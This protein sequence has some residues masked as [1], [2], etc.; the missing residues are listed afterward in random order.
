M[1]PSNPLTGPRP[2][3]G[4]R[5][6]VRSAIVGA[7]AL[8]A[9][10]ACSKS[11]EI[12]GAKSPD[13]SGV[14]TAME[15]EKCD[16]SSGQALDV[17]GDGRPDIVSVRSGGRETCRVI[18]LNHDGHPDAFVYFDAS[19]QVR[20][21]ESDFDR[22]GKIDEIATYQN[23]VIVRK[24]RET[25]LDGRLDTW[26]F[27]ENGKLVRRLRDSQ[28]GGKVDQWWTFSN[29]DKPEC[30]V[31]ASDRDG[32]G[33][34]DPNDVVDTCAE[35]PSAEPP[36]PPAASADAGNGGDAEAAP[37]GADTTDAGA[38]EGQGRGEVE[39]QKGKTP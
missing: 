27:Y 16:A 36:P 3:A 2:P 21:R 29:P 10:A 25:N 32:D 11:I 33:K 31:I 17:N 37:S 19:G 34:P 35:P 20:R 6:A 8:V 39:G 5:A 13:G 4:R 22:D 14:S 38:S 28:G 7:T 1:T 12:G 15:H 23:G 26:D 18:D 9:V 30:A 24:D